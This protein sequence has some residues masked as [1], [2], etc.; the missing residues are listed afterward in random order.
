MIQN[1][2]NYLAFKGGYELAI[3]REDGEIEVVVVVG[4]GDL[5][6]PVDAHSNRVVC[7]PWVGGD[8]K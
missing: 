6:S 2:R 4:D 1:K 7:Y 8:H 3:L 5:A